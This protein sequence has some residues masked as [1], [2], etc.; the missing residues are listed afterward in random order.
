MNALRVGEILSQVKQL[1]REYHSLTGRP[2]GCTAEI[3]EYE[4]CRLLAIELAPVR[5]AGYDATRAIANG[6]ERLQIK[7]RCLRDK[8]KGGRLGS[9]DCDKEWD[10]VLLVL[11][12]EALDA[13][14]IYEAPRSEVVA[15]L[16][17]PGSK[18]RNDRRAL[19]VSKF[20]AIGRVL[21]KKA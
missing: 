7:T 19:A 6:V 18:S 12:D 3:G 15:A 16:D 2:L 11:L 5:Q 21:W 20:K 4:A 13:V 1:A 9:I 10:Y 14:A 8:A 17:A